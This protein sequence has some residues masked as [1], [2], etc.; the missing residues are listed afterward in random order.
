MKTKKGNNISWKW[1]DWN[2][3]GDN[4]KNKIVNV[5]KI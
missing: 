5:K 2:Y 4:L 3:I 1:Y